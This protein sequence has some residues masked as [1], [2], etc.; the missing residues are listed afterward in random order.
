MLPVADGARDRVSRVTSVLLMAAIL[1]VAAGM[2]A[3]TAMRLAIQGR[4]V[5]VPELVGKTEQE[6][7]QA[8]EKSGLALQVAPGKRFSEGTPAGR[9]VEQYPPAGTRLKTSRSVRV[10]LSAGDRRYAVPNLV[11]ASRRAAQL[12]LSQRNFA[13]GHVSMARTP[14]GE[15]FTVQQQFPL[16]G[17]LEGADPTVNVLVS[18]GAVEQHYVMPDLVGRRLDQVS[19]RIRAEGFQMGKLSFQKYTAVRP[20]IVTLQRPQAGR[21]LTRNELIALE[22]SQ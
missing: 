19:A 3:I 6:A 2:S 21:R 9:V 17:S 13:L 22:V 1:C 16:P 11:G 12:T 7:A 15:P 20:G 4:E 5:A 8:L 10:L 18:A 14:A